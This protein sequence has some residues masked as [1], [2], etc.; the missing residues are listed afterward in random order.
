MCPWFALKP[1]GSRDYVGQA[2]VGS[3]P[4]KLVALWLDRDA[5]NG[6]TEQA[7]SGSYSSTPT[8]PVGGPRRGLGSAR[9]GSDKLLFRRALWSV[10]AADGQHCVHMQSA[11]VLRVVLRRPECGLGQGSL[12]GARRG[13]LSISTHGTDGSGT[14]REVQTGPLSCA[15]ASSVT[16]SSLYK[17]LYTRALKPGIHS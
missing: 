8:T 5:S 1:R 16:F 9:E 11:W 12:A 2:W 15:T 10:A 3:W 7:S 14:C 6:P 4:T 17:R 13:R